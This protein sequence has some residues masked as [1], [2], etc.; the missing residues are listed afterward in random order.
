LTYAATG[1]ID[2]SKETH[3]AQDSVF[4]EQ[5]AAALQEKGY[6][7]HA[8]VGC[9]GFFLDL[10]VVDAER[11]G[12]YVLG[13]ECDGAAYHNARSARD[14]DRLRQAVLEGLNWDLH[15]IWSTDWFR[16]PARELDK[17]VEAID[18][19]KARPE[20]PHPVAVPILEIKP[21]TPDA[22]EAPI[23]AIAL[24]P[25]YKCAELHIDL[26]SSDLHL[27]EADQ[28]SEWLAKV[29]TV[30][31]PIFWLEATRRVAAAVGIQRIGN[32]IQDAFQ[33]AC[34]IGSRQGRFSM[35]AG[36]LWS[37]GMTDAPVRDRSDLGSSS[38]KIEYIAPEE[39]RAAIER[40]AQDSYGVSPGD[41]A[42]GACRMLGFAR[43]TDE[44]RSVVEKERDTLIADGRLALKG[45]SLCWFTPAESAGRPD[46]R[47]SQ[48]P[49]P[50]G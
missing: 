18:K 30:E 1:R 47:E 42:N 33:R 43:V 26:Q 12:R 8:Q 15:R 22:A 32:R 19:A 35:R 24:P 34:T 36:F 7:V 17:L 16:N 25:R 48:H 9:A 28:L 45:E 11:P 39:I 10:A 38:R 6:T 4:E 37:T 14:R 2:V 13:I 5:V 40:V 20:S 3:R 29:V 27:V 46:H 21:I 49:L 23:V 44:M 50:P 41:V 31:S